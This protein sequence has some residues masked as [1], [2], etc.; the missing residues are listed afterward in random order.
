MQSAVHRLASPI[1]DPAQQHP[2]ISKAPAQP[3]GTLGRLPVP[4]PPIIPPAGSSGP[5][6]S[7][8]AHSDPFP[9]VPQRLQGPRP[10][11]TEETQSDLRGYGL[12]TIPYLAEPLLGPRAIASAQ[13]EVQKLEEEEVGDDLNELRPPTE[14]GEVVEAAEHQNFYVQAKE[15]ILRST[16]SQL[17]A[18]Y[19]GGAGQEFLN[20]EVVRMLLN[21]KK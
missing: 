21:I 1:A 11:S 9:M 18:L 5:A 20:D 14:C 8:T 13:S 7:R 19:Q 3:P 15:V 4:L 12:R 16:K 2:V 6:T 10:Y 17:Q